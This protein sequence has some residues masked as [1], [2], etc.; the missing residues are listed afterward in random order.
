MRFEIV[1]NDHNLKS[2]LAKYK[3]EK[4]S[5]DTIPVNCEKLYNTFVGFCTKQTTCY[6]IMSQDR[7]NQLIEKSGF[8]RDGQHWLKMRFEEL[9]HTGGCDSLFEGVQ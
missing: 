5:T 6:M 4:T 3:I 8:S 9:F 2:F 1:E 7:F